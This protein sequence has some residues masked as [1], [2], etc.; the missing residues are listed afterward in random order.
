MERAG[1]YVKKK[2]KTYLFKLAFDIQQTPLFSVLSISRT[3][4][5]FLAFLSFVVTMHCSAPMFL[6]QFVIGA[7][8]NA[9]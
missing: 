9:V 3:S 8:I 7:F 6:R 2:L 1:G 5:S 4:V